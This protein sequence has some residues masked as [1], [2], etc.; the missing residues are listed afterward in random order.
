VSVTTAQLQTQLA[1]RLGENQTPSD[2]SEKARRL[3]FLNDGLRAVYKEQYFWFTESQAS[4]TTV[5]GQ[6]VYTLPSTVR[7]L[8]EVRVNRKLVV[9]QNKP[10]A[11]GSYNYPPLYYQYSSLASRW[12]V[13]G[14]KTLH[15]L[16]IPAAAPGAVVVTAITV[17]GTTATVT[18]STDHGFQA[19]DFVTIAGTSNHN[20]TQQIL[21][22]PT[23]STFT[24]TTAQATETGTFSATLRNLT[25]RYF[26]EFVALVNDSD[27]TQIPD[28]YTYGIVNFAYARKMQ[29]KG[30]RGSAAD[31]FDEFKEF[32]RELN[33][34]HNR[35][36]YFNKS[37]GPTLPE[38]VIGV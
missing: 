21:T 36:A 9:P 31:G 16:P 14:D 3:S 18:C 12:F 1:Y 38:Y 20:G 10:D 30:R 7:D 6:E 29:T 34:E 2:G 19:L 23:A 4:D 5:I 17:A 13:T 33:A 26:S 11:F 8:I 35:R 27:T 25:Y 15:I 28:G 24:Y 32:I 22:T 37:V